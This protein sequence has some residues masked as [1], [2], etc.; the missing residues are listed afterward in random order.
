MLWRAERVVV[1]YDSNL[2]HL[3]PNQIRYDKRKS[4][5]LQASSYHV[6]HVTRDSFRNFNTV[7]ELFRLI[8]KALHIR[9][10][11]KDLEKYRMKRHDVI[12]S[13][14]LTSNYY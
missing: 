11:N 2:V 14:F 5:A 9:S 3:S 12:K 7:E 13:L 1:E 6:I 10:A 4:T 8:R